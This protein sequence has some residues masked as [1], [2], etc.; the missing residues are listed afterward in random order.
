MHT[1]I[2]EFLF[3]PMSTGTVLNCNIVY[4]VNQQEAHLNW[5][6]I[7][8]SCVEGSGRVEISTVE[9]GMEGDF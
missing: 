4:I 6:I 3:L 8:L 9:D 5:D 2:K 1:N 7:L